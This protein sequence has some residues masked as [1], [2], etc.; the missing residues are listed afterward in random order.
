MDGKLFQPSLSILLPFRDAAETLPDCLNSIRRQTLTDFE[1]LAVDDHS[2]DSSASIVGSYAREDPRFRLLHART[3]GLVAALNHGLREARSDLIARMDADDLM[4]YRR[5]ELQYAYLNS[6]PEIG[7]LGTRV[8]AFSHEPIRA[9]LTEYIRWQNSCVSPRQIADDIYLESPFAHPSVMFRRAPIMAAG[10]YRHG[11]FPEDYDL[12]LRLYRQEVRMAKLP[13]V[14]LRWRDRP[15]RV[16]R[17]D[18]RCS[19]QA[20]DKLRAAALARDPRLHDPQRQLVIWGAGRKTR[21][22]AVL[23]LEHGFRLRAWVDID[24]RK[25]GNNIKGVPVV[26]P[27]WLRREPKPLVLCYVASHGARELIEAQLSKYGYQ[28]GRNYLQV[29]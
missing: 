24:P 1:L 21:Q 3:Q 8:Q 17:T 23:L 14:L 6:H 7:V 28:K 11:M 20:F 13:Q 10:G 12:W 19:R 22:R 25:I 29:G 16:T 15:Q 9:G 5:L 18:P 27:Q 2:R 26:A 4:L